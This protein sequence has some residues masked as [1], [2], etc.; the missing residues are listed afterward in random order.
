MLVPGAE[1]RSST[2]GDP[3]ANNWVEVQHAESGCPYYW[4]TATQEVAWTKP[5]DRNAFAR[6]L[7]PAPE[8]QPVRGV[9]IDQVRV[10]LRSE[11][12]RTLQ[13]KL[14]AGAPITLP[15]SAPPGPG[16]PPSFTPPAGGGPLSA[17]G[18]PPTAGS[19]L[20]STSPA[21]S[22]D[23]VLPAPRVA[24]Q[25]VPGGAPADGLMAHRLRALPHLARNMGLITSALY[26]WVGIIMIINEA[27]RSGTDITTTIN[28]DADVR[29]YW[30]TSSVSVLIILISLFGGAGMFAFEYWTFRP[31]RAR[32]APVMWKVRV[33]SYAALSLPGWLVGTPLMPPVLPATFCAL[34]AMVNFGALWS[35]LPTEKEWAW[36]WF[37]SAS[38]KKKADDAG[39]RYRFPFG[40]TAP[41]DYL[42]GAF[43]VGWIR[44]QFERDRLPRLVFLTWYTLLNVAIGV[45]AFY[46]HGMSEK[47]K[48]LRGDAFLACITEDAVRPVAVT[49]S[50]SDS[51]PDGSDPVQIPDNEILQENGFGWAGYP[52]AKMFGQLLNLNCAV[53]MVPVIRSLVCWLHNLTSITAPRHM[54]WIRFVLPLDKNIVFHKAVAKY[55]LLF[56]AFMHAPRM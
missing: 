43:W 46:R 32:V 28:G 23:N 17:A 30:A 7:V 20:S 12:V 55:Y 29:I 31:G 54:Q 13:R 21:A 34:T 47:G 39:S 40:A 38:E 45:H 44:A 9:E 52:V 1:V 33:A 10:E 49:A 15:P 16:A 4:N 3:G 51:C 24:Q 19:K 50:T 37:G 27:Y 25:K 41:F 48:A 2:A 36:A 26:L 8:P 11:Q 53:F 42:S 6:P 5:A 35:R 56:A 14:T 18:Q 22:A